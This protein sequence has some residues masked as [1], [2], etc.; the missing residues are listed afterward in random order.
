MMPGPFLWPF[1]DH[2]MTLEKTKP[3]PPPEERFR[4][5]APKQ[6]G[7]H[8]EYNKKRP[9]SPWTSDGGRRR[10]GAPARVRMFG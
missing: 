7:L 4:A 10:K 9:P 8:G 3:K 2:I 5:Q 6:L 1:L